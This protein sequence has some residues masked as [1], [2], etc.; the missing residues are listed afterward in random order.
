MESR[1]TSIFGWSVPTILALG[2]LALH[3]SHSGTTLISAIFIAGAALISTILLAC[4]A[5]ECARALWPRKWGHPGHD[6]KQLI[7]EQLQTELE[8]LE[9]IALG[10][11]ET[12]KLND[13]R[14]VAFG[15]HLRG[16]WAFFI[17]APVAGCLW[18]VVITLAWA[19]W[20]HL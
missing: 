14:L 9:S 11:S 6:P 13:A 1:A 3:N 19:W 10:Y 8:V 15:R 20:V 17:L 5:F 18:I 16:A 12:A 4:A 7:E 2:A